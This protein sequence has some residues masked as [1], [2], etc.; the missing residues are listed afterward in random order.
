MS[1]IDIHGVT[2]AY[3]L[4]GG[5]RRRAVLQALRGIDLAVEEGEILSLVGESGCGKSTLARLLIGIEEPSAGTITVA[6]RPIS[7]YG[8]LERARLIQP[9]FQ[10][11]YSSLNPRKTVAAIVAAPLDVQGGETSRSRMA[12]VHQIMDA[13]GLPRYLANAYPSQLSG[14][15]RQ[16]VAIARALV[17]RPKILVCDEPT[18]ALDVSV[19][20]Q[21]L[22]LLADLHRAFKL[23]VVLITHNLAVVSHLTDRVAVMYLGRIVEVGTTD[24]IFAAPHHPYTRELLRAVLRPEPGMQLPSLQLKSD[25]PSPTAPPPGCG[26]NPRCARTTELCRRTMPDMSPLDGRAVACHHP[27]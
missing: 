17:G 22:N 2:R 14:G 16:R 12:A 21:I 18:S 7:S 6:G 5:L 9:V 15:Q 25:F 8:R 3:H 4:G 11:P 24:G 1:L 10:D 13:V 20:A 26:F 27:L 19:Q 23:T